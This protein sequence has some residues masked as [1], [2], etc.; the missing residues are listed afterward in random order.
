MKFCNF[1]TYLIGLDLVRK[2]KKYHSVKIYFIF[3]S[4]INT[5]TLPKCWSP[6]TGAFIQ[7]PTSSPANTLCDLSST[8]SSVLSLHIPIKIPTG[9]GVTFPL[10]GTCF[11]ESIA[12]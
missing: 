5:V 1:G 2:K 6:N 9:K 10:W 7:F 4:E 3:N 12:N 8:G 11:P